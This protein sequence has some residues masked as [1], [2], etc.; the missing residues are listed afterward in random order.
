M[1]RMIERRSRHNNERGSEQ[2]ETKGGRGLK[3][4]CP[5]NETNSKDSGKLFPSINIKSK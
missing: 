3:G 4:K 2:L 5:I 1:A